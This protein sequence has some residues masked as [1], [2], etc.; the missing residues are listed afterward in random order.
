LRRIALIAFVA[1]IGVVTPSGV[2]AQSLVAARV[3]ADND[4]FNFWEAPWYRPDEEYTNGVR[5]LLEYAGQAWWSRLISGRIEPCRSGSLHC[6]TR[7]YAFGQSIYTGA[8]QPG[9]TAVAPGSRPNAGWLYVEESSRIATPTSLDESSLTLGVTG[10]PALAQV[11]QRIAHGYVPAFTKPV[12]WS[13]QLPAEPGIGIRY[14]RTQRAWAI[15]TETGFG[16]DLEPHA[17]ASFGNILTEGAAGLRARAG[18]GM[19]HPWMLAPPN[20]AL[21]LS[22]FGDATM[23][24]V[25]R[26][27]FLAGT[28]FRP[29]EHVQERPW[30]AEYQAGLTLG[31]RRLAITYRADRI[32]PEYVTRTSPHTW[33]SIEAEWRMER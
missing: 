26:N 27:E 16:A 11:V 14:E 31:W 7:T 5:G 23:H 19:H 21:T 28:F 30:V 3:R 1:C 6:A 20:D 24:G 32:D 33:G 9:D 22:I 2:A 8:R 29:S 13:H 18:L 10:N 17:G 15:G 25:V 4:A 12:D